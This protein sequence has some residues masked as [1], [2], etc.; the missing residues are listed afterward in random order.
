M[1]PRR[2]IE[3]LQLETLAHALNDAEGEAD[4]AAIKHRIDAIKRRAVEV[5]AKVEAR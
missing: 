1:A 5:L 2:K 4:I 3:A